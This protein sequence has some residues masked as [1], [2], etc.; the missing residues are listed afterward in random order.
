MVSVPR[1]ENLYKRVTEAN[2]LNFPGDIVE[3][4]CWHGGSGAIMGAAC[5]NAGLKRDIW[6]FDSFRGLPPP[7]DNDGQYEHDFFY[8]GWCKGDTEKVREIFQRVGVP[9]ENL[10]IV[11]GWFQVTLPKVPIEHIAVLHV[12]ADWYESVKLVL[13]TLYH[14]VVPGGFVII[15]DYYVW[16]GCK[17][18]V[19]EFLIA[20][21]IEQPLLHSVGGLAV[22]FQKPS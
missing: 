14:R 13:E 10:K 9:S 8:D 21:D 18:A 11:P 2:R 1:L 20:Q 12:D 22:Y 7:G 17:Q 15:D 16:P 3:C 5:L 6:L 4:G 19:D